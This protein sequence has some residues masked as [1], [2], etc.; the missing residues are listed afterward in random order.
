MPHISEPNPVLSPGKPSDPGG[1]FDAVALA[2]ERRDEIINDLAQM[3]VR[4]R[5][6]TPAI[7]FLELHKPLTSLASTAVTFSQP[8]LGALFGFRK[9]AEWAALLDDRENVELLIGRIEELSGRRETPRA[10]AQTGESLAT[11]KQ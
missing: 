5:L 2:P 10:G 1:P 8:T 3:V 11:E 7:F 4:R 6:E 9:M